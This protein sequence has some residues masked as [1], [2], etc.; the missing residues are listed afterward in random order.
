MSTIYLVRHAHSEWTPDENRPLSA[1]GI[2]DAVRVGNQLCKYP[3]NIIYSSPANRACQT[4]SPLAEQLGLPIQIEPDLR[5]RELGSAVFDDFF[6]AVEVTWQD[7]SFAHPGGESSVNAQ[8]RGIAVVKRLLK[9]HPIE[10]IVLS[11]HGNL[12]T[13]ILQA[14]D[15]SIDFR[16]WKSLSMPD[17]Y[18]LSISQSG[19]GLAQRLW[20]EADGL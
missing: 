16:F 18:K 4:I 11:T 5:E 6:K 8:K 3:I 13:L 20:Q 2:K 19:K 9:R 10:N 7:P 12:M 17:V 1:K 14:F 15:S